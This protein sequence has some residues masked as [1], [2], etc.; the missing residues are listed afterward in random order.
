MILKN[1]IK[2]L[3]TVLM[4]LAFLPSQAQDIHFS[5]FYA[6]PMTLNPA[7]TGFMNN[8]HR[9]ALNYRN[10]YPQLYS[11]STFAVSYDAAL[12]RGMMR[13]DFAGAGITFY[14]DR[15]GDGALNNMQILGSL[16]YHKAIDPN[17][18]VLISV[19]VQGGWITK[20]INFQD[21]VFESQLDGNEFNPMLPNGEAI[22]SNQFSYFD[23]RAGAML[24]G[25]INKNVGIYGGAGYFHIFEPVETFLGDATNTLGARLVAHLGADIRA[26]RSISIAPNFIFMTQSAA[27]EIVVGSNFGYHFAGASKDSDGTA[28]YLG[29]S[30]RIGD[31][32]IA[33]IGA[34][35]NNLKIGI[36]YDIN[37]STLK[38][39]SLGQG[40]IE[41]SVGY[42]LG[43]NSTG[44]R[45]YPPVSC[46]RF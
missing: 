13:N 23:L 24:S 30:Y 15:Q 40:G 21:L 8:C 14:N 19:G 25:R 33:L 1:T 45:G 3:A 31:N 16:A 22:E 6:S 41:L 2:F 5:Q 18:K 20:S 9:V 34:E 46:P 29:A 35:F 4:F 32:V 42:E 43:C 12:M 39:A 7:M 37:L 11:Y 26:T 28:V 17:G 38:T 10:Q 36:S 44:R 27:R